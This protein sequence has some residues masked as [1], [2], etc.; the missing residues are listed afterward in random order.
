MAECENGNLHDILRELPSQAVKELLSIGVCSQCI[1]RLFGIREDLYDCNSLSSSVFSS[2][3]GN[4]SGS[5]EHVQSGVEENENSNSSLISKGPKINQLLC[6]LCLGIL[7][8]TY[9]DGNEFVVRKDSAYEFV[10]SIAELVKQDYRQTDG[11]S[12]E[13]SVPPVI[14][15]NDRC[16]WL[17]IKEKYGSESWFQRKSLSDCISVKD[18]LKASIMKPLEK[19]LDCKSNMSTLRIR[20]TYTQLKASTAILD[21]VEKS[22]VDCKRRKTVVSTHDG[23][24]TVD[25]GVKGS[26]SS[27]VA[28]EI[29]ILE[30]SQDSRISKHVNIFLEKVSEPCQFVLHCNRIP[31]Y[32]GGR[33]LKYSRNVSQTRWIIDDERMGDASVEELIGSKILPVCRG[34]NYKFHAAGREDIDVRMLGSGRPFLIEIQN[35]RHV[36]SVEDVKSIE[37]L[38]NHSDSKLVGVKNLKTVDSQ[39][40]TLMREGE[41]EKQKQYVALVW[42]SRP[43]KDEDFESVCSFKELKVMQKT[44][45]RVLHRRSPLEREKIIH[46]MKMEKVVGSSQYFLLHL[47]TQAGT[48]IKEFVHGDLGRTHPSIGSI[49]GCRAEILQLD[50]TDVKMDCFLDEQC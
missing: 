47:C 37:K 35:A 45:I 3:F 25:N 6:S 48:Y 24:E 15:E 10:G 5:E 20:M 21:F 23:L 26:D 13:V 30:T 41:S 1:L 36:P 46:W 40:W 11:F 43:L 28:S 16:I 34:D 9:R 44:P 17:Y 8:F 42:I 2:V 50:V 7:Q 18:A 33:Y 14:Q 4:L 49:L 29:A 27:N 32:V 31:I 22:Q 12:L 38:I 39:V 19:L